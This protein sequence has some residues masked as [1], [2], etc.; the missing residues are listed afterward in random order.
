MGL[1]HLKGFPAAAHGRRSQLCQ[2]HRLSGG[3]IQE[4]CPVKLQLRAG[5]IRG[6]GSAALCPMPRPQKLRRLGLHLLQQ[7]SAGS[8]HSLSRHI[9]GAGRVRTGVVGGGVGIRPINGDLVGGAVQALR[10]HLGQDGITTRSHVCR[11]DGQ[12]I[13][14]VLVELD[15]SRAHIHAG[16][17]GALHC[18]GDADTPY[19]SVSHIPAGKFFLPADHLRRAH[20][21]LIQGTACRRLTV[22]GRHHISLAHHVLEPQLHRI[23]MELLRQLVHGRLHGK[24]PLG[25]AVAPVGSRRHHVGIHHI[26]G[27]PVGPGGPVQRNGFM[28]RKT[29]GRWSVLS[30]CSGIG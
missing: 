30:I 17:P 14:A 25:G 15:G 3:R 1:R 27:K 29:H 22:I 4:A 19:L 9:G 10:R 12:R 16:D 28:A 8:F 26:I 13:I 24:D 6:P 11:S 18:H 2:G 21:T 7:P 20:Q 5:S 23:H